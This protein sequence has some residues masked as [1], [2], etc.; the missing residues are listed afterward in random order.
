MRVARLRAT[1]SK[2]IGEKLA[3]F[4]AE[5]AADQLEAVIEFWVVHHVED[6]AT[7]TGF[8]IGCAEDESCDSGVEDGAGAHGAGFERGV[9]GAAK[10]AVVGEGVAGFAESDDLGV[11]CGVGASEDAILAAGDDFTGAGDDDAA[12]GDL[13]RGLG[14]ASLSQ[15]K[16]HPL[17]IG[18]KNVHRVGGSASVCSGEPS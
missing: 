18:G 4:L 10:E 3:A 14:G 5:D 13:A 17:V 6:G 7:G 15:G 1:H 8:G 11:C 12:D 9:Q 2:K 16:L